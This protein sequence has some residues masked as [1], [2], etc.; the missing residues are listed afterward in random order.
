MCSQWRHWRETV[1]STVQLADSAVAALRCVCAMREHLPVSRGKV[2]MDDLAAAL[3]VRRPSSAGRIRTRGTR[4]S[5]LRSRDIDSPPIGPQDDP[6]QP[7]RRAG[8][9]SLKG[10]VAQ[11]AGARAVIIA[12]SGL[13]T[14]D[15]A[16][17][18]SKSRHDGASAKRVQ[19]RR[20]R[21]AAPEHAFLIVNRANSSS[22]SP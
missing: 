10:R 22:L 3:H 14:R 15:C 7:A 13:T 9:R 5:R 4:Q 6:K 18:V 11:L 17:S 2:K 20:H 21:A 19:R 16:L 12:A 1:T 8:H